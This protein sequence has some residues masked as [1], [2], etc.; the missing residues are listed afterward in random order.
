MGTLSWHDG[1]FS[2]EDDPWEPDDV[3]TDVPPPLGAG[4]KTTKALVY[5]WLMIKEVMDRL[6]NSR[7]SFAHGLRPNY[8]PMPHFNHFS[9][10]AVSMTE[11][12]LIHSAQQAAARSRPQPVRE[13]VRPLRNTPIE[14]FFE[15]Y[16]K[17]LEWGVAAAATL[18]LIY[19]WPKQPPPGNPQTKGG[20]FRTRSIWQGAGAAVSL[21]KI[22]EEV[23]RE[24]IIEAKA[25]H[26]SLEVLYP[27]G[28]GEVGGPGGGIP[29]V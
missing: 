1:R 7:P 11:S 21:W 5:S 17:E 10:Q 14:N 8:V 13:G 19:F 12:A 9:N 25:T 2:D 23:G 20:A 29:W 15:D 22:G 4:V 24:M 27:A 3:K 28:Y 6:K 16:G 26:N 18:G